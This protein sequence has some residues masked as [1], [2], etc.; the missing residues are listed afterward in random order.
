MSEP[1]MTRVRDWL[2]SIRENKKA[3]LWLMVS[4]T[5]VLIIILAVVLIVANNNKK[6]SGDVQDIELNI[7][8]TLN[9]DQLR[10]RRIDG[11]GVVAGK[12]NLFP[13]AI[14][15]ENLVTVRPQSGLQGAQVVY[16]TLA[17]GGIT[18][19]MAIYT[20]GTPLEE[21]TPVRSARHYFV[22]WA[23]EYRALYVH[24]GGSPQALNAL[25]NNE[26]VIDL[27][28]I[29]GD[30]AY[31][32][33]D[34]SIA[35][36]HNLLTSTELLSYALRDKGY[37]GV[38]G[39]F[40][41]W[42][43]EKQAAKEDRPTDVRNI[44]IPFSSASYETEYSYDRELNAYTR[45]NGGEEHIDALTGEPITVRN[46]VVQY[47]STSLLESDTGR[48]DIRTQGEG[49]AVV[50]RNGVATYGRWKKALEDDR[51]RFYDETGTE[52]RFIPGNIWVEV[53]PDDRTIEV[54]VA[55][56]VY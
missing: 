40:D 48:L 8:D 28:Q 14:M 1:L 5:V 37:E 12:E 39:S 19:F 30:H 35:A 46:V 9:D 54:D 23:E 15:V 25:Y 2:W 10:S 13:V 41:P 31:F 52:V 16:E 4:V 17:E 7:D 42:L 6:Q 20:S 36:P 56:R 43:F 50:F 44:I 51:T 26:K 45:R 47:A 21:I 32:W 24:A 55:D 53:V 3:Q 34:D 29:S 18:R 27:S 49:D 33:R 38:E 11:V 22:D